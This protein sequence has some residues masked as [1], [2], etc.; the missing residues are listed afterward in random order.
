MFFKFSMG[1]VNTGD[2]H[3][4]EQHLFQGIRIPGSW[5]DRA[6]YFCLLYG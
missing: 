5:S 1:E 6:D 4:G 3:T 2:V